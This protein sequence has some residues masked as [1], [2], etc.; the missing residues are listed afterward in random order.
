MPKQTFPPFL[1]SPSVQGGKSLFSLQK[2]YCV[3][4]HASPV[5]CN[6]S[7]SQC[8]IRG[9]V[10]RSVEMKIGSVTFQ[11]CSAFPSSPFPGSLCLSHTWKCCTIYEITRAAPLSVTEA[12]PK[13]RV[14]HTIW[15]VPKEQEQSPPAHRYSPDVDLSPPKGATLS[16]SCPLVHQI[17]ARESSGNRIV[18]GSTTQAARFRIVFPPPLPPKGGP[19]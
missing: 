15:F 12:S 7:Q 4:Q 14:L 19:K 1:L 18:R 3:P 11:W 16:T 8:K 5:D 2:Q 10:P 6:A 17:T 9:D 13:E